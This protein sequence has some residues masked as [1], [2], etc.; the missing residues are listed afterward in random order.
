MV[1][2]V[3]R[4]GDSL[5]IL[6]R[7][8]LVDDAAVDLTSATGITFRLCTTGGIEIF[9]ST[10]AFIDK[11]N[12]V[13]A[14]DFSSISL[15]AIIAGFYAGYFIAT[16]SGG[17]TLSAPNG[18]FLSVQVATVAQGT[19]TYSGDPSS[20][21]IDAVRFL[22]GDTDVSI[23]KLAD[24]EISWILSENSNNLYNAGAAAAE[25]IAGI[26][27]SYQDKVVG[28]LRLLHSNQGER[29]YALA[30]NIRKR[31]SRR[32]GFAP[33]M[34]QFSEN[35]LVELGFQDFTTSTQ[36]AL[37]DGLGVSGGALS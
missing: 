10:A 5:P 2:V 21:P 30:A 12:G 37:N 29:Y 31:R 1:D 25:A 17:K 27:A 4:Q 14:F 33:V 19:I 11:P 6:Q 7:T 9:N 16:F 34:T 36:T 28:P 24:S 26:Y 18:G 23:A 15:T 3:L 22:C 32:T 13:V 20:R 35:H 8:F